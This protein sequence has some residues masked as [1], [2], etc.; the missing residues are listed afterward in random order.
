MKNTLPLEEWKNT[1]DFKQAVYASNKFLD[2]PYR[3]PEGDESTISRQFLRMIERYDALHSQHQAELEAV[4]KKEVER[5]KKWARPLMGMILE[6]IHR[7]PM[8]S[9]A[10]LIDEIYSLWIKEVKK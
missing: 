10:K 7:Q 3:D 2:E 4:R 8:K 5:M 1:R 6:A 9:E